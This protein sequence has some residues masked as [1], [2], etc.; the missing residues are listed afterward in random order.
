MN[1]VPRLQL[2]DGTTP[3]DVYDFWDP[4]PKPKRAVESVYRAW[5]RWPTEEDAAAIWQAAAE[6]SGRENVPDAFISGAPLLEVGTTREK[7][8]AL[9]NFR[10]FT[11][12]FIDSRIGD[13]VILHRYIDSSLAD[14]V[15]D[16]EAIPF[17]TLES[18]S[19]NA[20]AVGRFAKE[21]HGETEGAVLTAEM[22]VEWIWGAWATMPILGESQQEVVVAIPPGFD[23][24]DARPLDF[25]SFIMAEG[26]GVERWSPSLG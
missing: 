20:R 3:D 6:D 7:R 14:R 21:V 15:L 16:G 11:T 12:G 18:W 22:P 19:S 23:Y 8:D 2:P 13:R 5:K 17:R 26:V 4:L 10:D 1:T 25:R 24:L 9:R